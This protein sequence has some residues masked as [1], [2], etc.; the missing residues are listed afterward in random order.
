MSD[1]DRALIDALQSIFTGQ[2]KAI[3]LNTDPE[4]DE[5]LKAI[6]QKWT[7]IA[8]RLKVIGLVPKDSNR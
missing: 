5:S 2:Q 4:I 3:F 1:T 8:E 6:M 7:A